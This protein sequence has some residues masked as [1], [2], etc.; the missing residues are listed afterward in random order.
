MCS[1]ECDSLLLA[2]DLLFVV[3]PEDGQLDRREKEGRR[4]RAAL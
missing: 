3:Y 4:T 2:V 1:A